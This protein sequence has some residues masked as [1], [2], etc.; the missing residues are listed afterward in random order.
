MSEETSSVDVRIE[1]LVYGGEGLARVDGQVILVPFVLPGEQVRTETRRVKKDFLR[2][3]APNVLEAASERVAPGCEYFGTCGGCQYQHIDYAYQLKQKVAILRET[4]QRGSGL[5]FDGEIG[6]ISGP[7]WHYRNRVQLHFDA[8]RA[9]FRKAGSHQLCPIDHC[10][11]SSP[12]ISDAIAKLA[13]MAK[14]SPWPSF[15]Q[16]LEVFSNEEHLQLVVTDTTRPVAARFFEWCASELQAVAPGTIDYQAAGFTFRISRGSFFQVNRFLIDD[17]VQE[18]LR[19]SSGRFAVDLYAGV[20]LFS[21]PLAKRYE[22]VQAI[23][24][25]GP[26]FR[27]LEWNAAQSAPNVATRKG[28]AEEFLTTLQES[29]DLVI[30]DPPRAGIGATGTAELL[31]LAPERL[32]LVSCDPATLGRD[33]KHLLSGYELTRLTLVD[34]FPQTY[35]FESIAHLL[36]K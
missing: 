17:L 32:V 18:V 36:R 10:P 7:A 2:G 23:E 29:P 6:V 22:R 19:D 3:S 1:K 11:I 5:Q 28:A 12:M 9:G 34:L 26:A 33:L 25:G 8:R 24:R 16:S 20:G 14:A 21:L 13:Q 30:S 4:L 31:R 27:D 15:L 35:H